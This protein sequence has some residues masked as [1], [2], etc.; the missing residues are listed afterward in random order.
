MRTRRIAWA[1]GILTVVLTCYQVRAWYYDAW[2]FSIR[3][4]VRPVVALLLAA[5]MSPD[6]RDRRG[7]TALHWAASRNDVAMIRLL[8]RHGA[9]PS[10]HS[11]RNANTPLHTAASWGHR[12]AIAELVKGGADL[13]AIGEYGLTPIGVAAEYANKEAIRCL[14]DAGAQPNLV[15]LATLGDV[16]RVKQ[17]LAGGAKVNWRYNHFYSPVAYA[18]AGDN[19]EVAR[20]LLDHGATPDSRDERGTPALCCAAGRNANLAMVRLLLDHH[21]DINLRSQDLDRTALHIA[22]AW[23]RVEIIRE[24]LKRGADARLGDYCNET[25]QDMAVRYRQDAARDLLLTSLTAPPP[26]RRTSTK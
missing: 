23:G 17:A 22:A 7:G 25:P 6:A 13:E 2:C 1:V 11:Y 4:G 19:L 20:L 12:E 24:L 26:Y 10:P 5:G 14:L 21:A 9:Q 18:V 8:L 3:H 15:C 16:A